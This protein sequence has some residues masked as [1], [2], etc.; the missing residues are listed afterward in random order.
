[1]TMA[2]NWF[3]QQ[4]KQEINPAPRFCHN[5]EKDWYFYSRDPISKLLYMLQMH[6]CVTP[7]IKWSH[8]H[9]LI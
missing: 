9:C 3:Q 5:F 6:M 7:V 8:C 1:M 4:K 2:V